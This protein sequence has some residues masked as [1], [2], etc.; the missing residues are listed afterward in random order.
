[1]TGS[2]P[3]VFEEYSATGVL[4]IHSTRSDGYGE[5]EDIVRFGIEAG[6]DF[7]AFNDHRNLALMDE[8]W[9]GR[10]TENLMSIVGAELQHTDRKNHLLVYGVQSIKPVG[11]ILDQLDQVLAAGGLAVI[12]HPREKR[13]LIP[14]YG[15]YPW[16]FGTDNSVSGIEGWN[17]MSSWKKGVTPFNGWK[18]IHNP[19]N[20]VRNPHIEAVDMW[21]ETGG[22]LVGG[23]DAHGHRFFGKS[24]FDYS[25]LFDRIR[26]HILLDKP[27]REP[28]QFTE[29]LRQGRC[30]MSNAIAGD[31]SEYRSLV[32]G[33]MLYLKLP[34][35]ARVSLKSKGQP[36]SDSVSLE[37]GIHCLGKISLPL[38]I[39][40]Q[41]DGRTWIAQGIQQT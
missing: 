13:P 14:G 39:E 10:V 20:L 18:R 38:Y 23:A 22:C 41:R 5:P 33:G 27:F 28:S 7:I 4:H 11:H 17:W 12:A 15:E 26:T 21:F 36:F 29:A 2:T 8:G 34:A 30:F 19:D 37:K 25:M 31:A 1:M 35:E 24:V 3:V 6:L 9:H 16:K 40:I 32:S